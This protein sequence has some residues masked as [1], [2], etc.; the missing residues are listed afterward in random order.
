L[1]TQKPFDYVFTSYMASNISTDLDTPDYP[2]QFKR[3]F[4]MAWKPLTDSGSKI[5]VIKD[6]PKM[7]KSMADC[8]GD[9]LQA[10][11]CS[12]SRSE[13]VPDDVAFELA[14]NHENVEAL[15]L[16]DLI[17]SEVCRSVEG[18]LFVYRDSHHLS[19]EYAKSMTKPLLERFDQLVSAREQRD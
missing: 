7:T 3:G 6:G 11:T 13:G 17:C 19:L 4:Y 9:P 2:E 12:M 15:D 8:F 16:T 14:G 18:G 5:L 1:K 10:R